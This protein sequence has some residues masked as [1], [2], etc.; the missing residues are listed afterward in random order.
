MKQIIKRKIYEKVCRDKSV[1][2]SRKRRGIVVS[3]EQDKQARY[4]YC[5]ITIYILDSFYKCTYYSCKDPGKAHFCADNYAKQ[6]HTYS[7]FPGFCPFVILKVPYYVC[8]P[9]PYA[10]KSTGTTPSQKLLS[11]YQVKST[12]NLQLNVKSTS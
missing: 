9:I 3:W 8:N 5:D 4:W 7:T 6:E 2:R 12:I 11:M 1:K 10:M